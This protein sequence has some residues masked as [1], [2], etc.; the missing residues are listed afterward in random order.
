MVA[1]KTKVDKVTTIFLL[2]LWAA[3][4]SFAADIWIEAEDFTDRGEWV[5]DTQ[6]THLMGSAY[7]MAPG[8]LAPVGVASTS[9]NVGDAGAYAVWVRSKDWVPEF[10]PGKFRVS[11]DGSECG[12]VL[13]ASGKRGWAWERVSE[14]NLL[15]GE[16]RLSLEDL[17]GAFARCDVVWLTT[18]MNAVP[19]DDYAKTEELRRRMSPCGDVEDAGV[20][21]VVVVGAGPAGVCAAVAAARG[22]AKT[23]LVHDRPVLG[24]NCSDEI[25]IRTD[26]AA[27][28]HHPGWGERGIVKEWNALNE[29]KSRRWLSAAAA[30]LLGNEPNVK[31]FCNE[32]VIGAEGRISAVLSR[33]TMTGKRSRYSGKMFID[34]TGDGW[35]GFYA[36]AEYRYGRESASEFGEP[37]DL[38]P[39][40]PDG[41]TMSGCLTYYKYEFKARPVEFHT[42]DWA[43]ILP[44]GFT[45]R[46][47]G[48]DRP[49]WLEHPN[50]LDDM[51]NGEEA[52][53]ELIRYVFAYWGWL[54]NKSPLRAKAANAVLTKVPHING[55]RESRRL[56]GDYILT[57]NDLIE[58]RMFDD[59]VTYGG[60]G[61][62]VHD[63]LGMQSPVSNGWGKGAKPRNVPIYS[64]PYRCL[65]SRNIPNL[66]MAGRNISVTHLAL[67]STRVGATCA[68]E[69]QVVGT[70]AA[71]CVARNLT[72]RELGKDIRTLQK[73]L[74][75]DG[76]RIPMCIEL[77]NPFAPSERIAFFGDSITHGGKYIQYIQ[78]W[79][80]LRHPGS[81]ALFMNCGVGGNTAGQAL[82]RFDADL[83][84]M[85]PDCVFVMFGMNDVGRGNYAT[86]TP[87]EEQS[88]ARMKSLSDFARNMTTIADRL[89]SANIST[90]FMTPTPYDQYTKS[91]GECLVECNEPGLAACA[92][93]VR[94]IA[95]KRKLELVELH[96]PMTGMFK[97]NRDFRCCPDR[98]HPGKEGHL[99]IAA[100]ILKAIG[101]TPL[102]AQ[103][104][105]DA[106]SLTVLDVDNAVVTNVARSVSG[107]SFTYAPRSLPFPTLPEYMTVENNGLFPLT[108]TINREEIS[109][110]GLEAGE[111]ELVFDGKVVARFS[112][113]ELAGGVNVAT[114]D[115]ENQRRAQKAARPM[116]EL[117]EKVGNL[118]DYALMVNMAMMSG[119]PES[120]R[121]RMDAYF[122]KWIEDTKT[123]SNHS[124][125]CAFV[126]NYRKV[127][128]SRTE[129]MAQVESLRKAMSSERPASE[130]VEVRRL[131]ESQL[132]QQ[133]LISEHDDMNHRWIFEDGEAALKLNGAKFVSA[134]GH[135]RCLS[136]SG[137]SDGG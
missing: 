48:L 19:D 22:G 109:V 114:L 134:D 35:L 27:T 59:R 133:V 42:P 18:D 116:G 111:Y 36:G 102:V 66:F 40:E 135:G 47:E 45:R 78:L 117:L 123:S 25:G 92:N 73:R 87:T 32:R 6:F 63:V 14:V 121:S 79:E 31:V 82:R 26:G 58:G 91:K 115:T 33:N 108:D 65:Y 99:V 80:G 28:F 119:I 86:A 76:M 130:Q 46:V 62:D 128:A 44:Q 85:K 72:P 94:D 30:K 74:L 101:A 49:W 71:L 68:T 105:V 106:S 54:K 7:L 23:A 98:V 4:P 17:C 39:S 64:I 100:H 93:I 107:V 103:A 15:T 37:I 11:I 9:F 95:A 50:S 122:D 29:N 129:L 3:L 83:L 2:S 125:F 104:A 43:D 97:G 61:L 10:H 1:E 16:H 34:S 131:V 38:A 41:L 55:R 137:M 81:G 24:G 90:A 110:V 113:D 56:V 96:R 118:R 8:V 57:A 77:M 60:W 51:N 132:E 52:R 89:A 70:A 75:C 127:R 12:G 53:D 126:E 124:T 84:P 69:G 120:D 88:S 5:V 13:G 136:F 20:F 67:G 112:A 21:D